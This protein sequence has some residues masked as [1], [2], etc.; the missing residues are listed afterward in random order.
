V[1]LIR[2][3]ATYHTINGTI[4]SGWKKD[5]NKLVMDVTVPVNTKATIYVPASAAAQIS[6][7]GQKLTASKD[8]KIA[9]QEK[10]YV[11]LEAGSGNY[12]FT[13]TR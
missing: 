3:K 1:V 5:G 4:A 6:L 9:G 13:V 12:S 11:L 10:D 7:D 8:V 2:L